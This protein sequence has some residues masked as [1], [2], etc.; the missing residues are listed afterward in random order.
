MA[1]ARALEWAARAV[2]AAVVDAR[3]MREGGSPWLVRFANE[4]SAILRLGDAGAAYVRQ[5]F[6]TE[7]AALQV[8]AEHSLV[9]S[10]LIASDL[11]GTDAG[12]AAILSTVLL[13]ISR[14]PRDPS[15]ERLRALGAAAAA[16]SAVELEPRPGLPLLR[17]S[18]DTNEFDFS[19]GRR[20]DELFAEAE[21]RLNGL[22]VPLGP[23]VFVHGDL[24]QGNALWVGDTC[25]GL[26]DWEYAGV[27]HPGIDL[28]N[29]RCDAAMLNGPVEAELVLDGWEQ[30]AGRPA[31]DVAYWDVV[32]ALSTPVGLEKWLSPIHDQG[33]TDL[34]AQAVTDRRNAFL[35]A[36]LDR[37]PEA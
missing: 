16:L 12:A 23:T 5:R 1:E 26:I 27:G 21:D 2:G 8:A 20:A 18:M 6:A 24:W 4:D 35:R 30:A 11:D 37:L 14:V 15:P 29:L 17:H 3:G 25:T 22:P 33:R 28:G 7:V 31:E 10:R 34:R 9:T 19:I 36:A 32:A 13:G